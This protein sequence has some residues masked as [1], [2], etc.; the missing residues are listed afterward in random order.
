MLLFSVSEELLQVCRGH[1]L[2]EKLGQFQDIELI[3]SLPLRTGKPFIQNSQGRTNP[4]EAH[5]ASLN[6]QNRNCFEYLYLVS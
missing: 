1:D 5:I 3:W 2:E 4:K 6:F